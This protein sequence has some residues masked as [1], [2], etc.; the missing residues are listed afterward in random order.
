MQVPGFLE[1][2]NRDLS[3]KK[4]VAEVDMMSLLPEGYSSLLTVELKKKLRRT[5]AIAI[6]DKC[7]MLT[8]LRMS[9]LPG[10]SA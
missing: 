10:C 9:D 2:L 8:G 5:P 1:H 7:T 4:Q 6:H 3:K